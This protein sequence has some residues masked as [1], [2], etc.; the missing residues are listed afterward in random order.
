M[1]CNSL[2]DPNHLNVCFHFRMFSSTSTRGLS[3]PS[4]TKMDAKRLCLMPSSGT[5][6]KLCS[7]QNQLLQSCGS[8]SSHLSTSSSSSSSSSTTI[9]SQRRQQ[10]LTNLHKEKS[11]YMSSGGGGLENRL[12]MQ[13]SHAI[14]DLIVSSK[15]ELQGQ[16]FGQ[17]RSVTSYAMTSTLSSRLL[18]NPILKDEKPSSS[19]VST[20]MQHLLL[21]KPISYQKKTKE[22]LG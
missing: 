4:N 22:S 11:L 21:K 1:Y 18:S 2:L 6:S 20:S 16:S 12:L 5:T 19:S 14:D 9:M 3:D 10:L 7:T 8:S 13:K 15:M 17:K